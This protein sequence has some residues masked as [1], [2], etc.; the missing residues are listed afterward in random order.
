MPESVAAK[1]EKQAVHKVAHVT[2]TLA[3]AVEDGIET[4]KRVGKHT[5]DAAEEFM[6]DTSQRIK[7]HPTESLVGAFAI[8]FILGGMLDCMLRRK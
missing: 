7:R 8:G 6:E 2:S 4:A 3:N 5:S 1:A